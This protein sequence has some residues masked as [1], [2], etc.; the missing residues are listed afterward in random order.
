MNTNRK[1]QTI[2]DNLNIN[3]LET[4]DIATIMS[5]GTR[6][7]HLVGNNINGSDTNIF[8][9]V[10][11][12]NEISY[13]E[14]IG[15][16]SNAKFY[17]EE[18]RAVY[19]GNFKGVEY[20]LVLTAKNN[21]WF[22]DIQLNASGVTCEVVYGGGIMLA[23]GGNE[24]YTCQY[25][26]NKV[27]DENGYTICNRSTTGHN[28][29]QIGCFQKT[30]SYSTDGYQ[31]FG[32]SYRQTNVIE[33]LTKEQ[34]DNEV[35]QYEFTY[36]ALQSE[37]MTVNGTENITFYG[38]FET[39]RD[40]ATTEAVS[41]EEIK[42]DFT[43]NLSVDSS[44]LVKVESKVSPQNILQV[45]P[46]NKDELEGM[47][48]TRVLEENVDGEL[49]SFFTET[50][51]HIVMPKKEVL[52]ERATGH[53]IFNKDI[54][55]ENPIMASTNYMTGVFNCHIVVGNTN[56]NK[57]TSD[58]RNVLNVFKTSG[59]R[60]YVNI[61]GEYKLLNMPSVYEL[62]FNYAKWVYKLDNDYLNIISYTT[63]E[64]PEVIMTVSSAS[65]KAY[66]FIVTNEITMGEDERVNEIVTT[67]I[68]NGVEYTPAK[69]S[70][71]AG[72]YPN[73]KY[74]V[75][76]DK[77]FTLTDDRVFFVD[78][79]PKNEPISVMTLE[80]T[81]EFKITTLGQR[82]EQEV[83]STNMDFDTAKEEYRNFYR[84]CL[85]DFK[86]TL[87][88]GNMNVEKY[89]AIAM[90]YTHN[91]FIHYVT[92]HGLE[93]NSGAA[94]GCRDVCQGPM[95]YFLATQNFDYARRT[96]V[97]IFKHQ[98][99]E[100]GSWPQWFM[101]DEFT[102]IGSSHSHGDVIAWPLRSL[103]LY[104]KT[105]GDLS[106]LDEE[107]AYTHIDGFEYTAEKETIFQH[108]KK[109][110]KHIEDTFIPNTY[111]SIYG[112]GDWN[113]SMCP[114]NKDLADSMAS[115]WTPILTYEGLKYLSLELQ[116][117]D[118]EYS[119]YLSE[120][121]ENIKTDCEKHIMK[122]G[123]PAGFVLFEDDKEKVIIHPT[124]KDTN[125]KYRLLPI[126]R[127]IISG[128]FDNDT[129]NK[130]YDVVMENL[131]REDGA[132]LFSDCIAYNGGENTY[133][134]RAEQSPNVGRE[135]GLFYLHAH[136]RF[137]EAVANLGK[138]Q[139]TWD[140]LAK[141]NP[142]ALTENVKNAELRQ[143]NAYFSSSDAN[144]KSK[145]DYMDKFEDVRNGDV[146]VKGGWKIYSSGPGI[147]INLLISKTLG[148]NVSKNGLELN[149]VL[150]NTFDGLQVDYKY[151]GKK[152]KINYDIKGTT[153][154][155]VV[156]N[157][158]EVDVDLF[159]NEYGK[160]TA[161][162]SKEQLDKLLTEE[163][164]TIVAYI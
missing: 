98:Y 82:D 138:V 101:F 102:N 129:A 131:Y 65:G 41:L 42:K 90:W 151:L 106:I 59:Q 94:W 45:L 26:D 39:G 24:P 2:G 73:I 71:L 118:A 18:N 8:L 80:N 161:L 158:K 140:N 72:K 87:D 5:G 91:A 114:A 119:K 78:N 49:L 37:K 143:C 56:V 4:G 23:S 95:E 58:Y 77:D 154:N 121:S 15:V 43:Q 117:Y 146:G 54:K 57:F 81:S 75:L 69:N 116:E 107:V 30:T 84:E 132:M 97:E 76:V 113:D 22:A 21:K 93:Q 139:E 159:T 150:D 32:L 3:I 53:I 163:V 60:I 137:I 74:T 89:N 108:I 133:F 68:E 130:L 99:I 127:G 124:D 115:G 153:I 162:I 52:S 85:N 48:G 88:N 29:A 164:N 122:D 44:K 6:I 13:T 20:T 25:I 157:D 67:T 70:F 148:L 17:V 79:K 109:E 111:L 35:Y 40:K 51:E 1:I 16:N 160:A 152:I 9:K 155:K 36:S 112:G 27:F 123:V 62:G 7:N 61:E 126:N 125:I 66:D 135:V 28:F 141:G 83:I 100:D 110:I 103:A 33:A 156:I 104:L 105:T 55:F 46:L 31:F 50:Y 92:P 128:M 19:T 149:P 144:V 63:D 10:Y 147:Y 134:Q 86:L 136:L 47:Y 11:E 96:L 120:M 14:M 38:L 64:T 12:G 34:L 145:Y 142:I